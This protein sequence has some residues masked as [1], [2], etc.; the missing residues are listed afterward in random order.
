[1]KRF[2]LV[3][4]ISAAIIFSSSV[5]AAPS[6]TQFSSTVNKSMSVASAKLT[7]PL[8]AITVINATN[9]GI[10]ATVPN[11][12]VYQYISSGYNGHITH[13][14]AIYST[15][16]LIRDPYQNVVFNFNLCRLAIVTVYGY[17]GHYGYNIDDHLCN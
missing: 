15:N 13:P 6:M 1:M 8:T 4:F 5:F 2:S 16:V 9:A 17:Y 7:H 12:P 11:T 10:Y 14:D 3:T